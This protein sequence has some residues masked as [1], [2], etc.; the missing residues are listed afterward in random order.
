MNT[1]PDV[2]EFP[3]STSGRPAAWLTVFVMIVIVLGATAA[4]VAMNYV[5]GEDFQATAGL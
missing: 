5:P 1:L 4:I 3:V 2:F